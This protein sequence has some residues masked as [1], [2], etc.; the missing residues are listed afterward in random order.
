MAIVYVYLHIIIYA[1]ALS[2]PIPLRSSITCVQNSTYCKLFVN[3]SLNS[4]KNEE[5]NPDTLQ[6]LYLA[7]IDRCN[8]SKIFFTDGW[9]TDGYTPYEVIEKIAEDFKTIR[10]W[11][12]LSRTN[13]HKMCYFLC[14]HRRS[15]CSNMHWYP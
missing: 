14:C 13:S 7:E 2:I 8:T 1:R 3:T 15:K 9:Y 5:T 10:G 11:Y 6:Q 4:Y 12:I